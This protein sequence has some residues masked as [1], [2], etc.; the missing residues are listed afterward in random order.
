MDVLPLREAFRVYAIFD[1]GPAAG[2]LLGT[3][4]V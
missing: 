2:E 1:Y 3:S 4:R